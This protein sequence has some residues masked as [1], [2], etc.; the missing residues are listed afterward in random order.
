MRE[1]NVFGYLASAGGFSPDPVAVCWCNGASPS[2]DQVRRPLGAT[3]PW[4][5]SRVILWNVASSRFGDLVPLP[6][7]WRFPLWQRAAVFIRPGGF[8]GRRRASRLG[9]RTS[10]ELRGRRAARQRGTGS[11]PADVV[12]SCRSAAARRVIII[13][14]GCG[15]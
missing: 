5:M 11:G 14:Q 2:N 15:Q 10:P 3:P 7:A 8:Q 4:R 12:V 6:M 1:S 9:R 13:I